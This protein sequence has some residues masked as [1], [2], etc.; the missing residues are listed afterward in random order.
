MPRPRL[1]RR[2]LFNPPVTYFKPQGIPLSQLAV[3][4]LSLEEME[5]F[6]WRH[7]ADLDQHQA[8]QKMNT[9]TSTYQRILYAASTKIADALVNGKAISISQTGIGRRFG[10]CRRWC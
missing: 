2:V 5:A 1:C 3:V 4:E 8:A 6:R 10:R 9:S 7:L